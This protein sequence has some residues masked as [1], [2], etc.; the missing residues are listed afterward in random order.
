M[1]ERVRRR[2][3]AIPGP[4]KRGWRTWFLV[5]V[6]VIVGLLLLWLVLQTLGGHSTKTSAAVSAQLL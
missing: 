4:R 6:A 5:A 1:A 2:D 3:L